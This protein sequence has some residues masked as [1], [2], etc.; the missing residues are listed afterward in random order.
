MILTPL[1]SGCSHPLPDG[2]WRCHSLFNQ[3]I[4]LQHEDGTLLTLLRGGTNLPP[5]GWLLRCQEYDYLRSILSPGTVLTLFAGVLH[6]RALRLRAPRRHIT[7]H[8]LLIPCSH[9]RLFY[10]LILRI[11]GFAAASQKR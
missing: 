9:W 4:N 11:P 8:S 6:W 10:P 3:A 2:E 5:M 7:P 1:A